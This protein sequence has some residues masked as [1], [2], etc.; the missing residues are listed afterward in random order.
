MSALI[1]KSF[2]PSHPS[3]P[4]YSGLARANAVLDS[5]L[6]FC[7]DTIGFLGNWILEIM[8]FPLQ[9]IGS[10]F[11]TLPEIVVRVAWY[12]KK[13]LLG[14]K[15]ESFK[16][17]VFG[18]SY[19]LI[20]KK[21]SIEKAKEAFK[22]ARY[23]A[24]TQRRDEMWLPSGSRS[25]IDYEKDGLK[26]RIFEEKDQIQVVYGA[27]GAAE[28]GSWKKNLLDSIWNVVGGCPKIYKRAHQMYLEVRRQ[29]PD[30]FVK[31]RV[32]FSGI[33]L[34]GSL[35]TYVG[36]KE[37]KEVHG[38]NSLGIGP[39]LMWDIGR[40]RLRKAAELVIQFSV[41]GDFAS[42]P[43]TPLR[44]LDW[45]VNFLGIRTIG[46]IGKCYIIPH[47]ERDRGKL[48]KIHVRSLEALFY[49]IFPKK[50]VLDHLK[51]LRRQLKDVEQ[52]LT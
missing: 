38:L 48:Y 47:L 45:I 52:E 33:C 5:C 31:K 46:V 12:A 36:L 24:A 4:I 22:Y 44:L 29:Y 9:F 3:S 14:E 23:Y 51:D 43:I 41:E 28:K 40:D 30:L 25:L 37:G 7:V 11:V 16:K 32:I 34:G 42:A 2:C 6:I 27:L 50:P 49:Y 35:A 26:F 15:R 21:P 39:G 13:V 18:G 8:Q 10:K 17:E 19:Q 1:D 20:A